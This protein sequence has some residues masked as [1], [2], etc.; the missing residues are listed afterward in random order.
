MKRNKNLLGG[1]DMVGVIAIKHTQLGIQTKTVLFPINI[2][3]R[4]K[5]M[6]YKYIVYKMKSTEAGLLKAHT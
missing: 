4:W 5:C 2:T 6:Y 3:V 1:G